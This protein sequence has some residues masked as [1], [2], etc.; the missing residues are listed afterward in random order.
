MK[1]GILKSINIL[2]IIYR[3]IMVSAQLKR[4]IVRKLSE[5]N[6]KPITAKA[7]SSLI[8]KVVDGVSPKAR[9][10]TFF[11]NTD[12]IIAFIREH[13]KPTTRATILGSIISMIRTTRGYKGI[14]AIYKKELSSIIQANIRA[15]KADN[16]PEKL[17]GKLEQL[18]WSTIRNSIPAFLKGK[19]EEEQ[20]KPS[21]KFRNVFK[22]YELYILSLIIFKLDFIERL[23][24]RSFK[25]INRR[26]DI[27]NTTTNYIT[28]ADGYMVFQD[29][30]TAGRYGRIDK[31]LPENIMEEIR[32]YKRFKSNQ[33]HLF[34]NDKP[35]SVGKRKE[36][37]NK[38]F[39]KLVALLSGNLDT[40]LTMN[41]LRKLKETALHSEGRYQNASIAN[42]EQMDIDL[43]FHSKRV[44]EI[45]YR[46][47]E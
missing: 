23:S 39:T 6:I 19:L 5:A 32:V 29:Y 10:L 14:V 4:V 2:L 15:K 28:L 25:F 17:K 20:N 26:S 27:R 38:Q 40:R 16:V 21:S 46:L 22:W 47:V 30:K 8:S 36:Y 12:A 45:T 42:Q 34:F 37:S 44:G 31:K 33:S 18:K 11:K 9:S 1:K 43:L 41:D 24:Y 13:Y 3:N 35:V 7:Y